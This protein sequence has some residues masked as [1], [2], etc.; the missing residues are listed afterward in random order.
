MTLMINNEARTAN[1]FKKKKIE[2]G[3][4]YGNHIH[5][6]TWRHDKQKGQQKRLQA[7]QTISQT[8]RLTLHITLI[9][10]THGCVN[11]I[12]VQRPEVYFLS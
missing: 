10:R 3:V 11:F 12:S 8:A 4:L 7:I 5:T 6:P 9:A 1:I 2:L